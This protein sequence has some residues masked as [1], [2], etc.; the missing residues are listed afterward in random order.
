MLKISS[1]VCDILNFP[2]RNSPLSPYFQSYIVEIMRSGRWCYFSVERRRAK[3]NEELVSCVM[4][5]NVIPVTEK[6]S[7][8]RARHLQD[9]LLGFLQM[10]KPC[11]RSS[12]LH[13]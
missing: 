9:I 1:Y 3:V 7:N 12:G 4:A 11:N 10:M 13:L 5:F 8:N 6:I 2:V